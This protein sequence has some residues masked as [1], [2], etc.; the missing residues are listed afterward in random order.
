M[1]FISLKIHWKCD[2]S[3]AYPKG[4]MIIEVN[5]HFA[6]SEFFYSFYSGYKILNGF[7]L[8]YTEHNFTTNNNNLQ[9]TLFYNKL[10]LQVFLKL[11]VILLH[12]LKIKNSRI[13][14]FKE[15]FYKVLTID[16]Q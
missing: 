12:I 4:Q 13:S 5:Y 2:C 8:R 11:V 9:H 10:N 1:I 15:F 6:E 3:S 16:Y 7:K 14:S